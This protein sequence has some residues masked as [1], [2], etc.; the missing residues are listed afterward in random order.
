MRCFKDVFGKL[1]HL[2]GLPIYSHLLHG[3]YLSS[4][5]RVFKRDK[6]RVYLSVATIHLS[7]SMP[8]LVPTLIDGFVLLIIAR[9]EV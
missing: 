1:S 5:L 3:H 7:C 4:V 6:V 2:F 9:V 8:I